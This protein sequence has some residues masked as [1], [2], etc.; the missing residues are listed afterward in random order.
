M[1]ETV[2]HTPGP[3]TVFYKHKYDEWHVAL[4]IEGSNM[5]L[6][7]CP[8]G[9]QSENREADARLIA[10]APDMLEA[11]REATLAL[12]GLAKGEGVFKPIEQTIVQAHAAIAKAT[13]GSN[14]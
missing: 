5:K 13:G 1:S 10:A 6:A 3:W 8:D 7:L 14:A 4:P 2:K 9:I 11:L 12:D